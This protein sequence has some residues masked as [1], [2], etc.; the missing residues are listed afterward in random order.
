M[1][2]RWGK[3]SKPFMENSTNEIPKEIISDQNQL[4]AKRKMILIL[5]LKVNKEIAMALVIR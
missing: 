1:L 4:Q 2:L 3:A 5:K